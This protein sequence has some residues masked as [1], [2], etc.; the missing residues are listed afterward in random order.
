MPPKKRPNAMWAEWLAEAA[1]A[2]A[3][4]NSRA[5]DSYNK[6]ARAL[7]AHSEL[8]GHPNDALALP[9]IGPKAVAIIS[10][11]LENW[12][13]ENGAAFPRQ[14]PVEEPQVGPSMTD[15]L[16]SRRK[17]P[18]V[19]NV[20]TAEEAALD[21]VSDDEPPIQPKKIRARKPYMP[22]VRDGAWGILAALYTFCEPTDQKKFNSRE[23]IINRAHTYCNSDY[24]A[25]ASTGP[26]S[27]WNSGIDALRRHNLVIAHATLR[28]MKYALTRE[29]FELAT[30]IAA[31][32]DI[33]L[34]NLVGEICA[35]EP[36]LAAVPTSLSSVPKP[37]ASLVKR[38][39]S[40]DASS[41][42]WIDGV[43]NK[44]QHLTLDDDEREASLLSGV[45]RSTSSALEGSSAPQ[46]C[47]LP[48]KHNFVPQAPSNG[49]RPVSVEVKRA[50]TGALARI[51]KE[52]A[53]ATASDSL[54]DLR[55]QFS[56]L[57]QDNRRVNTV[58]EAEVQ[59]G[60][61]KLYKV[62][63]CTRQRLHPFKK[64]S[65]I[66]DAQLDRPE[67]PEG[68]TMMGWLRQT[69]TVP[70][71]PGFSAGVT[72]VSQ[73]KLVG[74]APTVDRLTKDKSLG[75][76]RPNAPKL[77]AAN[78]H[79]VENFA[80]SHFDHR[81]IA[82]NLPSSDS[83]SLTCDPSG[84][85]IP[86]HAALEEQDPAPELVQVKPRLRAS[87]AT[88]T[89]IP[90]GLA[91]PRASIRTMNSIA[92]TV[93]P[94][95]WPA[96]TYTISLIIDN[97]E[98]K[99]KNDRAGFYNDCVKKAQAINKQETA[100][101][102]VEQRALAAGDALWIAVH[103]HNKKEV[104]LDSIV[105]RKRLDDLCASIL[106]ARFHEQ[107]ARL[108]N[109][110]L[111][112]RI[113]LVEAYNVRANKEQFG[114]QIQT[115]KAELMVLDDCHLHETKD[116]KASVDY[117]VMRTD[118]LN[119]LH[120][121]IDLSVIPDQFI[122][123]I[124]YLPLLAQLRETKPTQYWVT[125][126]TVFHSLNDKSSNLTINHLWARM[127]NNINGM[128]TEKISDFVTRW[129]SPRVFWEEYKAQKSLFNH[130]QQIN[131]LNS[132]S[133][134][135]KKQKLS[136]VGPESWIEEEM[137]KSYRRIGPALSKKIW[138]LFDSQSY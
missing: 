94:E 36:Q 18:P 131:L 119:Q 33:A 27:A 137:S 113:Y 31:Q 11:R 55:F 56:Y 77:L 45:N 66:Q 37:A 54:G 10:R 32:E 118:V 80:S 38:K 59:D 81:V 98:V 62:E 46:P 50:A 132:M 93:E 90:T 69:K 26:K 73:P 121:N 2:A 21:D 124:N 79:E 122:D 89:T 34:I 104:V 129:Q 51:Y 96:G 135:I 67:G 111:R 87:F 114:Q 74:R 134:S 40:L 8:L 130:D 110:G 41:L 92:M 49:V 61:E 16:K 109:S 120:K 72:G 123:R 23:T 17:K 97:R 29:G 7:R 60:P 103:K 5:A 112:D 20:M 95:I 3:E 127:I 43:R 71:C 15:K 106:D 99:S 57:D 107:K 101:V 52:P 105:E 75:L 14:V 13:E 39:L 126:Y 25:G 85:G 84:T 12:C 88:A 83:D 100:A 28:P 65:I 70:I 58:R 4:K 102:N 47:V 82:P 24:G 42:R 64:N 30:L 35:A 133:G 108:K 116:S 138:N 48:K 63:F 1:N 53:P 125:S 44:S 6:A 136:E 9:G 117:L 78:P 115:S 76:S 91:K 86:R 68:P 19:S 128:S 22:K